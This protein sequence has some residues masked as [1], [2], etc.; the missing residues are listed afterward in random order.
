MWR[1]LE[2]V[3][4]LE[5]RVAALY[6]RY[7]ELF[8]HSPLIAAFWREMAG[9]ERLH[10]LIIAA[11]REVFP[12]TAPAPPGNWSGYLTAV[13]D[14]L[15]AI[16][17][18]VGDAVPVED[19]FA[20]AEQLETSELNMVTESIIRHA[21]EGFSRLGR[22]VGNSGVDRHLHKMLEARL[23]FQIPEVARN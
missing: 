21:G 14:S 13:A 23:R 16:E 18:R 11:A 22:L 4:E 3:A 10:A 12:V 15:S 6:D 9:D 7:A 17:G 19:A 5:R 8:R 1:L 2:Q 20:S